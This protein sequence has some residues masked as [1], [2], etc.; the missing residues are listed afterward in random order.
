MRARMEA[1]TARARHQTSPPPGKHPGSGVTYVGQS[2]LASLSQ[3]PQFP[4]LGRVPSAFF[5]TEIVL[6]QLSKVLPWGTG[7]GKPAIPKK[8]C[9]TERAKP[10]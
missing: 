1:V 6:K 9:R 3:D 10:K 8:E 2:D 4:T 5:G 7:D